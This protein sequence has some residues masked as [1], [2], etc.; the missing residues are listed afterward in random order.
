MIRKTLCSHLEMSIESRLRSK[1]RSLTNNL[2]FW[3]RF[4]KIKVKSTM[5]YIYWLKHWLYVICIIAKPGHKPNCFTFREFLFRLKKSCTM[6]RCQQQ[7]KVLRCALWFFRIRMTWS[8]GWSLHVIT[9][10]LIQRVQM[11]LLSNLDD[12]REFQKK[13]D[14]IEIGELSSILEICLWYRVASMFQNITCINGQL[15]SGWSYL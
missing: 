6:V 12:L 5:T 7:E 3:F 11:I 10:Q 15:V 2:S 4:W 13:E 9:W 1:E 14:Y 8:Y